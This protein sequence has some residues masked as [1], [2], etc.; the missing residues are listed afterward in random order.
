MQSV[1]PGLIQSART[2]R[3]NSV[4]EINPG[5]ETK[6]RLMIREFIRSCIAVNPELSHQSM[7]ASSTPLQSGLSTPTSTGSG[8]S[9]TSSSSEDSKKKIYKYMITNVLKQ[10]FANALQQRFNCDPIRSSS[11]NLFGFIKK[12][13]SYVDLT[14]K[15]KFVIVLIKGSLTKHAVDKLLDQLPDDSPQGGSSRRSSGS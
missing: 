10:N 15:S 11:D 13:K 2:E 7:L 8:Y 4:N 5:D 3:V 9:T 1:K 12:Q 14:E 6:F